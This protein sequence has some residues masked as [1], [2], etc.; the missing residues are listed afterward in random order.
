MGRFIYMLCL[1]KY[2]MARKS[3]T[4]SIEEE[5]IKKIKKIAIDKDT[6]VSTLL[7]EFI[8]NE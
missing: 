7:E 1:H 8:K 5:L 2:I 6:D 3:I 4:L